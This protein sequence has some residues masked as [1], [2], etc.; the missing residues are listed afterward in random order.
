MAI[1]AGTFKASNNRGRVGKVV[2]SATLGGLV[3]DHSGGHSSHAGPILPGSP[4][5]KILS[6]MAKL[7]LP[8]QLTPSLQHHFQLL[9]EV[10]V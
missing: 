7:L 6:V 10:L 5:L 3:L 1:A 2:A 8:P 4:T 9:P